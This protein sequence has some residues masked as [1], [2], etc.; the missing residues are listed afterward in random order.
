MPAQSNCGGGT[1]F[2][3]LAGSGREAAASPAGRRRK[4][5][6]HRGTT[7]PFQPRIHM[8][9]HRQSQTGTRVLALVYFF[10]PDVR[11]ASLRNT[12]ILRHL[13]ES[14]ISLTIVTIGEDLC[15]DRKLG[16]GALLSTVPPQVRVIRTGCAYPFDSLG[17]LAARVRALASG[18]RAG[19][20][21]GDRRKR[22]SGATGR[23]RWQQVKDA[24]SYALA[25][26]DF[27]CGWLPYCLRAGVEDAAAD[28]PDVIYAVG[29]P[30][31]SFLAG[32]VL[33]TLL[34]RPLVIDFMDPWGRAEWSDR[35]PFYRRLDA[36]M[37]AFLVKRADHVIA[38]TP[39]VADDFRTRLGVAA[40]KLSVLTCGYD[41]AE[42]PRPSE[43]RKNAVFTISHIGTL[44]GERNPRNL[45]L[46]VEAAVAEGTIPASGIRLN[47]VGRVEIQDP[48]LE[49]VRNSPGLSGIVR[50]IPWL[51]QQEALRI[52][53]D[54]D[55]ALVIQ[56]RHSLAVPAKL[57]EYAGL[58]KPVLALADP[59]SAI[60]NL[61][62]REVWGEVVPSDD[63]AAI[64]SSLV[65]F[66]ERFRDG[67][68][69]AG[70]AWDGCARY[71]VRG[72]AGRLAEILHRLGRRYREA[73]EP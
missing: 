63:I 8:T 19:G 5:G 6:A 28:P 12:K 33:K 72:L 4:T 15:L 9:R 17:R 45:L 52:V 27:Y 60:S 26:P 24:I 73:R 50:W 36:R 20:P 37:E 51:P 10:A 62:R 67:T 47:F 54:S 69:A 16:G 11:T 44:Y 1:P 22:E 23:S 70:W 21:G 41:P 31:T 43:Q 64:K 18:R 40:D 14:S 48:E 49:R 53:A 57:Y 32:Y 39:E 71:T 61:M 30:W 2:V 59:E 25:T 56:P 55:A 66:Y 29:L 34:C 13:P 7:G 58:R 38:N 65:R 42:L 3:I 68:L 35:P 46:A